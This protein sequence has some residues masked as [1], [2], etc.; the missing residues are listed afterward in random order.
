M[1]LDDKKHLTNNVEQN[2]SS[3]NNVIY[4]SGEEIINEKLLDTNVNDKSRKIY[5][6]PALVAEQREQK[7]KIIYKK[8][9]SVSIK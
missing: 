9:L 4:I 6:L 3:T 2:E 7:E 8:D 5:M 1:Q